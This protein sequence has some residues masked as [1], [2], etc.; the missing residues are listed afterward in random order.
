MKRRLKLPINSFTGLGLRCLAYYI[1]ISG[2]VDNRMTRNTRDR[3]DG[4]NRRQE[5][6]EKNAVGRLGRQVTETWETRATVEKR[7]QVGKLNT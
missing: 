5:R 7:R 6:G 3:V 1:T 2:I 4:K